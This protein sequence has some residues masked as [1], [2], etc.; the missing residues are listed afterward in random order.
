[1]EYRFLV[2]KKIHSPTTPVDQKKNKNKNGE[3]KRLQ[4]KKKIQS[5]LWPVLY[6][7]F[8]PMQWIV[9][10]QNEGRKHCV[11]DTNKI[12]AEQLRNSKKMTGF[13]STMPIRMKMDE[14]GRIDSAMQQKLYAETIERI[15]RL[16]V[17]SYFQYIPIW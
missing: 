4:G 7:L 11:C 8:V 2:E 16:S 12:K 14:N 9:N 15:H 1:M 3:N 6:M 5:L 17:F 13:P 10:R